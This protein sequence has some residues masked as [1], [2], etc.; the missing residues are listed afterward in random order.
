MNRFYVDNCVPHSDVTGEDVE[1]YVC[2]LVSEKNQ[3]FV[4]F[5]PI[6]EEVAGTVESLMS[7]ED[8]PP[9]GE[10]DLIEVI[11]IMKKSWES[12]DSFLSGIVLNEAF[13]RETKD[14]VIDASAILSSNSF[15]SVDSIVR[16][17][18][19]MSIILS[20]LCES[21]IMIS[22]SLISKLESGLEE[23]EVEDEGLEGETADENIIEIARKIMK[24]KIK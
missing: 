20:L 8:I 11:S 5:F 17:N 16:I 21:S 6:S 14:Y 23:T 1:G 15:G 24:G 12:L 9:G 18:F 22:D 3:N 10:T 7:H 13:D 19:T 4:L 2:P